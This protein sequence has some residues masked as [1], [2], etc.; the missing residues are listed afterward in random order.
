[1]KQSLDLIE[2]VIRILSVAIEGLTKVVNEL[3]KKSKTTYT[4]DLK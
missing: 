2:D 3:K 4:K 1:V